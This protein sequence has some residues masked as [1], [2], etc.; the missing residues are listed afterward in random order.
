MSPRHL[1]LPAVVASILPVLADPNSHAEDDAFWAEAAALLPGF[2]GQ[3]SAPGPSDQAG[4]WS[5]ILPWPHTPVSVA[6]LP[7]GK[8]LTFSGQEP[9]HWPGTKHQTQWALWDPGDGSFSSDLH[10]DHEMFCAHLVLR[11]DGNLQTTGGRFTTR[12]SSTY[13]WRENRWGKVQSMFDPRWYPTSVALPDGDVFTVSGSGGPNTAERYHPETDT[14]QRLGGINWQPVAGADGFES[15]WWPYLFVAPDGRLFH[16]GPTREMHW[17]SPDGRGSRTSA[18]LEVPGGYYSKHAGVVMYDSGKFLV[19]GGSASFTNSNSSSTICYTVDLNTTPP[20]VAL[21]QPMVHPRRFQ[22]AIVLPTGEV[23]IIGGNTSGL[24]FSDEGSILTPEI[25][26]PATGTWRSLADMAVPR[27]YHSTA[28]LLPD[29]RVF[30]GGGGFEVSNPVA[31]T[32]HTDAQLFTPPSLFTTEGPSATRPEIQSAPDSVTLGSVFK[33]AATPGLQRFTMIRMMATTHGLSTDQRFLPIPFAEPSPGHYQL[34]AHPN[35]N[36]MVPGF[37]ML[38]ALD[39]NDTYSPA[40]IIQVKESPEAPTGGLLAN[41]YADTNFTDLAFTRIDPEI[42]FDFGE[43]TP[44]PGILDADTWSIRWSGWLIPE[45]SETYTFHVTSDEGVRLT[46]DGTTWIDNGRGSGDFIQTASIDLKAGVPVSLSLE[47]R[48]TGGNAL[49]HLEWSS[50]RTPQAVIPSTQL[51]SI[52]PD[53]EAVMAA[54]ARAEFFVDGQLTSIGTDASRALRTAFTAGKQATLAI[55]ARSADELAGV[56]GQFTVDGES[57]ST[58]TGWKVSSIAADGWQQPG[59]DDSNWAEATDYGALGAPPWSGQVRGFPSGTPAHWIWSADRSGDSEVYLRRVVGIPSLLALTDQIGVVGVESQL[60]LPLQPGD[61]TGIAYA[62]SGLP[63]GLTLDANLGVVSGTPSATGEFTVQIEIL[64]NGV[65]TDRDHFTWTIRLPGQGEGSLLREVW[66]SLTGTELSDLLHH[67]GFPDDPDIREEI[68]SFPVA[69]DSGD[70][71]GSR[72]RGYLHAPTTGDYTLYLSADERAELKISPDDLPEHAL[73]VAQVTQ[74]PTGLEDW[75]HSPTQRSSPLPLVAGHRYYVEILH[76]EGTG[77]DYIHLAWKRPEEV[78][79]TPIAG[80]FFSPFA[81]NRVPEIPA[82]ADRAHTVGT[83]LTLP[84]EATDPDGDQLT[85]STTGLPAGL[86]LDPT[87]GEIHGIP[88]TPMAMSVEITATDSSGASTS[89][90]FF[91]EIHAEA[92]LEAPLSGVDWVNSSVHFSIQASGG[93]HLTYRWNFGDDSEEITTSIPSAQHAFTHPGRYRVSLT[94]LDANGTETTTTFY[95]NIRPV[96][97]EGRPTVSQAIQVRPGSCWNVNPDNG[98]VSSLDTATGAILAEIPTGPQPRSLAFAPDGSLWVA[99]A[100]NSTITILDPDALTVTRTLDLPRG[101]APFG[102]AFA[103]DGSAAFVVFEASGQVARIDPASGEILDL[104]EIGPHPRHLSISG[105]SKTVYVTRYISPPVPEEATIEPSPD[106]GGGELLRL[107]ANDLTL[108]GTTL[109]G[110]SQRPD[111]G[112]GARGIPNYLG[113]AVLSPAGDFAWIPSKQDNLQRGTSRDGL[114]LNHDATLRAITS[115]VDLSTHLELPERRIDHDNA[116]MPS[117]A[118]FD[119]F[120]LFLFVALEGSREVAVIDVYGGAEIFRIPVGF[121]PQG[122]ALSPDGS[123]LFTHNFM[124]RTVSLHA[125]ADLINFGLPRASHLATL[126]EVQNEALSPQL[127]RGKQLFYDAQDTRLGRESYISCASCH[128]DGGHDGR[129][130]DFSGFGEGLRNTI[131]LRG[132][133]GTRHGPLHWSGNFD[134]VQDFENQIRDLASGDGLID[135]AVHPP[136]GEPNAGRSDDLDA[137]AAYVSSLSQFSSSPYRQQDGQRT[138]AGDRG[139][140]VFLT[141]QCASCHGGENFTDSG[142]IP[143]HDIGTLKPS[144]G[145]RL[146]EP[147]T[148]IDTPTLRGL[149]DGAPFL[150]DGSAPDLHSAIQA[151]AGIEISTQD[152]DDLVEYLL[153]IEDSELTA[154]APALPTITEFSANPNPVMAGQPSL[155]TW[156]IEP[157]D[158]PLISLTLNGEDVL[159]ETSATLTPE[160][161]RECT[162]VA[163]TA[164]GSSSSLLSLQVTPVPDKGRWDEWVLLHDLGGIPATD[165]DSDSLSDGLEFALGLD[166]QHDSFIDQTL[167][168]PHLEAVIQLDGSRRFDLVFR[169]PTPTPTGASYWLEGTLDLENGWGIIADLNGSG[170]S[171]I[172]PEILNLQISDVGDGTE[173]V[174]S[175]L[176]AFDSGFLRLAVDIAGET[177]RSAPFGWLKQPVDGHQKLFAP[178]FARDA[179]AGGQFT[180]T[181][182]STLTDDQAHWTPNQWLGHEVHITS[183]SA[184][185]SLGMITGN[186]E[187]DL[188]L[189]TA[190]EAIVD[191]LALAGS[192]TYQVRPQATL[193]SLF[194]PYNESG[195]IAGTPDDAD[196]ISF[197]DS[198]G[199]FQDYYFR[200]G[201]LGGTGW[202]SMADPFLDTSN[203]AIEPGEGFTLRHPVS[204]PLDL[205]FHGEVILGPRVR[206]IRQGTRLVGSQTPVEHATLGSLGLESFFLESPDWDNHS[207][208]YLESPWGFQ[209]YYRKDD[210]LPGGQGWRAIG[211]DSTD[212]ATTPIDAGGAWLL[213]RF[214]D[215]GLWQRQQP[216]SYDL[217]DSE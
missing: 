90:S 174:R 7:T 202:R 63:D 98:S 1:L 46:V 31:P 153:Q 130:W 195:L 196:L 116:A 17:V 54:G 198:E 44:L 91:W 3:P 104:V 101:V 117:T 206:V 87:T 155:L 186:D 144:S 22:N 110:P 139:R 24:K 135:G 112:G 161:S 6:A 119:P 13:D 160:S 168:V 214:T 207:H 106:Q 67:P 172:A 37:W 193:A 49:I 136:L 41:Y 167:V 96:P 215:P 203:H 127:L 118:L 129:V 8:V 71:Y 171:D 23:L 175:S 80:S 47:H 38:F 124:S 84:L 43:K 205:W 187:N 21:T 121:A 177:L 122:L 132:R 57:F 16:F 146:G 77:S 120:G 64:L 36:V 128:N 95:Q 48:E 74:E 18:Q 69:V 125:V 158:F 79:I 190:H 9:S 51:R 141:A 86:S 11:S 62:A 180:T 89:V 147:L 15:D 68:T 93:T 197:T 169:R 78:D 156:A 152:L 76:V 28:L 19:A 52:R 27:N 39:E 60:A 81:A 85:F 20:T 164:A 66:T 181:D 194:G 92:N 45:F 114:Q 188:F 200:S 137:L 143:W 133:A 154:P 94:A 131:D 184:R 216:F 65:V 103:P 115:V 134:E 217:P 162:L 75:N 53:N 142:D 149:F 150:H 185:G 111:S 166:P 100:G 211:N 176:Y 126:G 50:P 209:P 165:T 105:D 163:T 123:V 35:A 83:A 72:L 210:S 109:L 26:N 5:D 33:V 151:H 113:P 59:F 82:I 12:D 55:H 107:D 192:G 212:A 99:N 201:G 148:G 138:P 189:G 42:H 179:V 140:Q 4:Q 173:E 61:S 32:T 10:L 88:T 73:T 56:I 191:H 58:D 170:G 70:A 40:S 183:G 102:L 182:G 178:P 2:D 199:L 159:G 25:W 108:L 157:G 204:S 14:W 30:S 208:V 34:V 29:G 145:Q 213:F 97:T